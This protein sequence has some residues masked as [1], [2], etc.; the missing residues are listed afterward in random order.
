[1]NKP[2]IIYLSGLFVYLYLKPKQMAELIKENIFTMTKEFVKGEIK[3]AI[4]ICE[5]NK[6]PIITNNLHIYFA[7]LIA[8]IND[9]IQDDITEDFYPYFVRLTE[10]NE[11]YTTSETTGNIQFTKREILAYVGKYNIDN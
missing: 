7:S 3:N 6:Q 2:D 8:L 4:E 5:Q 9:V 1:M 11:K 10:L